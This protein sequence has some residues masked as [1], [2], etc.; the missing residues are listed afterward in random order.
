MDK[1]KRHRRGDVREDGMVFRSYAKRY[2][3]GEYWMTRETFE[4]QKIRDKERRERDKEKTRLKFAEYYHKNKEA[5]AAK[6]KQQYD[7]DPEKHRQLARDWRSNNRDK[8]VARC[9]EWH[10][11]NRKHSTQY[12]KQ[13]YKENKDHL[14]KNRALYDKRFP[15]KR[16][17]KDARRRATLRGAMLML[18][19]DQQDI[20]E[21]IYDCSNRVS[22]CTGIQHHVDHI[23][24]ITKGGYHIH[25]NLQVLPAKLNISKSNK[26]PHELTATS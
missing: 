4:K 13:Y 2:L 9:K 23:I 19:R 16:A 10:Q 25:T 22:S 20:I 14:L 24:P 6:K 18:H 21:T 5:I 26:L 11:K 15:E 7:A 1:S 12:R 8:A 3:N 17:A